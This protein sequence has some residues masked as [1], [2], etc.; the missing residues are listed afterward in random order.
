VTLTDV[1]VTANATRGQD[2]ALRRDWAAHSGGGD[3]VLNPALYDNTGAPFGCGLARLIDQSQGAGWSPFNPASPDPDNPHLG[4]PTAV[5]VLPQRID[6]TAFGLDPTNTCGDDKTATTKDYRIETSADGVTFAVAKQGS[7]TDAD[8]KRLNIVT[9]TANARNVRFV[10]LTLL[11]PQ[12][13]AA[14]GSGQNFIDFSEIEV[15][16]AP[17]NTLPSGPLQVSA[18][19]V[20]Q[21]QAVAFDASQVTDPDSKI[22]GYHW[23]FDGNGTVDRVTAAPTTSYAYAAGGT[24]NPKVSVTDFRGGAGTATRQIRVAAPA[25]VTLPLRGSKG[26]ATARVACSIRCTVKAT[27]TLSKRQARDLGLKKRTAGTLSKTITQ[28][29]AQPVTATLSRAVRQ[30]AKRRG[31]KSVKPTLSITVTY[32]V[33]LPATKRRV[34]TI[35]L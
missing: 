4:S 34:V 15:F 18:G 6:I 16:G 21:G 22:T 29:G 20:L 9:P 11:T 13:D 1:D 27:V 5:I 32:A 8:R 14:G 33:G 2:V 7:F 35:K 25:I 30:A 23:D 24:F 28:T 17:P 19:T 3:V 12:S 10:R 31:I 26:K